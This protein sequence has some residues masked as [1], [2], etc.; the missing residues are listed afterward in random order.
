MSMFI[1]NFLT[2]FG[3]LSLSSLLMTF[4]LWVCGRHYWRQGGAQLLSSTL[5]YALAYA[6]FSLFILYDAPMLLVSASI[7]LSLG[8]SL[9]TLAVQNFRYS[10]KILRDFMILVLPICGLIISAFLYMP[11]QQ[12]KF[13]LVHSVIFL[14]QMAYIVYL[15]IQ[16]RAR[17]VGSGWGILVGSLMGEMG[18][19]VFWIISLSYLT[20]SMEQSIISSGAT[21]IWLLIVFLLLKTWMNNLGFLAMLIERKKL[22]KHMQCHLDYLRDLP[23]STNLIQTLRQLNQAQSLSPHSYTVMLVDV[24][25]FEELVEQYGHQ[26][27]DQV[28]QHIAKCLQVECRVTDLLT[29]YQH[30]TFALLLMNTPLQGAEIMAQRLC[31]RIYQQNIAIDNE[32]TLQMTISIGVHCCRADDQLN[33]EYILKAAKMALIKAKKRGRNNFVIFTPSMD[34]TVP[35]YTKSLN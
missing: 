34:N 12:I 24:D 27:G 10:F 30:K 9:F 19:V 22:L 17:T 8:L 20:G 32:Q 31:E 11:Q 4:I 2:V 23:K 6:T 29:L 15:F 35:H 7:L 16:L 25:Q 18:I 5:I 28:I 3:L 26:V 21:A 33:S 1:P 14:L 13:N